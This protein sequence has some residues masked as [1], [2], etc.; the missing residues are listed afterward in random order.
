VKQAATGT[1][2]EG[3]TVDRAS[4]DRQGGISSPL[5][6]VLIKRELGAMLIALDG[7][8]PNFTLHFPHRRSADGIK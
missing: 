5:F 2:T 7:H 1:V 3:A 4:R 6:S 8:A